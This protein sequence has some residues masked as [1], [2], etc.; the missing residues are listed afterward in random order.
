MLKSQKNCWSA[1][2]YSESENNVLWYELQNQFIEKYTK[3]ISNLRFSTSNGADASFID[4][5]HI[6]KNHLHKMKFGH[7]EWFKYFG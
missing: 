5:D 7:C 3:K 2:Y 1:L 4:K 6:V